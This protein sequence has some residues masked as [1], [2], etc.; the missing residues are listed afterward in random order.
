MAVQVTL[1]VFVLCKGGALLGNIFVDTLTY[2]L[3]L[4]YHLNIFTKVQFIYR[5]R[6]ISSHRLL[7][8]RDIE[9]TMRCVECRSRTWVSQRMEA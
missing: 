2:C 1:C 9:V 5:L 4:G 8:I 7:C 6:R 3:L